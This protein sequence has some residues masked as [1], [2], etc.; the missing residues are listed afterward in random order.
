MPFVPREATD[1]ELAR[2]HPPA[3]LE[4]LARLCEDGGG[5]L[6]ADTTVS[7]DSWRAARLAAGTGLEAVRLLDEGRGDAAFCAVRPPGPPRRAPA[8][9]GLLPGEQ[10]RR[11]GRPPRRSGR[12]GGHRRLRRPPRQRHP[13]PLLGRPPRA[14]RLHPPV[15][16]LPGD[17]S[18]RRDRRARGARPHA[19]PAPPARDDGRRVPAGARRGDRP[20]RRGL[21]AD[22]GPRVGR[23]RRPPRR[24]P[25][26]ARACPPATSATSWPASPTSLRGRGGSSCSSRAATT[27][28]PSPPRSAP[29]SPPSSGPGTDRRRPRAAVRER[30]WSSAS[31][32]LRPTSG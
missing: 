19:E 20:R 6:D 17:G 15:A 11:G 26:R 29:P 8:R 22:V 9:D 24:S 23:L 1:E 31:A 2:V 7:A 18:G 5:R 13:G 27:S 12:A 4:A 28:T 21:R 3:Y 32:A 25:D 30:R 16:A 10:H 14:L